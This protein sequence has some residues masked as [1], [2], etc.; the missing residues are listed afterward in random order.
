MLLLFGPPGAGKGTQSELLVE[1]EN[2]LHISTGDLFRSAMK[3]ATALGLKAKEYVDSGQLVP[4]SVT[5]GLVE[6][7][8]KEV[9][10]RDVILDG[11]PRNL[12]Q[13]DSLQEM[14]EKNNKKLDKAVFF[15]VD[16]DLLISR[17]TGRRICKNCGAVYHMTYSPTEKEGVCDK[18]GGE[19]YQREDDKLENISTRLE[20]YEENTR[21]LVEYYKENGIFK[22][23]DAD[24]SKEEIFERVKKAI[25][26]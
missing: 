11:F 15:Q 22:E 19:T 7:K 16:H 18:C 26:S 8:L 17:L 25:Y 21:P 9:E 3:Q 24:G 20:V 2:M 6:E 10:D 14:L 5:V 23:V 12:A 13:A 1:K 4:D